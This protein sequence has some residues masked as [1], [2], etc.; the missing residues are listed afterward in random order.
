M[1]REIVFT[2][3]ALVLGGLAAQIAG[4]WRTTDDVVPGG[5]AYERQAWRRIWLTLMPVGLMLAVLIG[6]AVNEP[7]DAEPV[8]LVLWTAALPFTIVG[9]RACVR[10]WRARLVVD[11][12][13]VAGTTGWLRPRVILSASFREALDEAAFAAAEAHERAHVRHRDPLRLWLAQLATDLQWP[14]PAARARLATWIEAVELAR[15]EDA[16][17]AGTEGADLAA[18]VLAAAR[19]GS[20]LTP[21]VPGMAVPGTALERRVR[22]LLEPLMPDT[23]LR[24]RGA[25]AAFGVTAAAAGLAGAFF[26]ERLVRALLG[27]S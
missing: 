14:W 17:E 9:I 6:W 18:A 8:P 24:V 5:R 3:L 25:L 27:A 11:E 23:P 13:V 4:W 12:R 16:R 22:R 26:G 19:L 15:D 2:I 20:A 1:D 10:A 21:N 7:A